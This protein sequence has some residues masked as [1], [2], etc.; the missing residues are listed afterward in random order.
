[1]GRGFG[2]FPLGAIMHISHVLTKV[3]WRITGGDAWGWDSFG[4]NAHMLDIGNDV[5][6][7][8]DRITLQVYLITCLCDEDDKLISYEWV[9]ETYSAEFQND[10]LNR[11]PDP[12][13]MVS[14]EEVMEKVLNSDYTSWCWSARGEVKIQLLDTNDDL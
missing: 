8:F 2:P 6:I 13:T 14:Y 4:P 12:P 10:C 7:V 5:S 3:Q 11:C 1:M 9:D